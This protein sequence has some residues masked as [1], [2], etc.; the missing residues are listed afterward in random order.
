MDPTGGILMV[1]SYD[2][3]GT[4]T[5]DGLVSTFSS[6]GVRGQLQTYPDISA[7]GTD[8]QSSC[9]AWLPVCSTGF[10]PVSGPGALD[11]AT[12]NTIS[13]TSMATPHVAG[14]VA[15][16]FEKSPAATPA[17][18]ESAIK[19]GAHQFGDGAPYESVS[20]GTTSFDK[21]A[22]LVDVVRSAGLV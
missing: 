19:G 8:I 2:D 1:A 16:L 3:R 12:F 4:G 5:R 21:G 10:A 20:G 11:V 17:A 15:Q 6:R 7:P 13:G 14:I 18:I 9:R 22:G